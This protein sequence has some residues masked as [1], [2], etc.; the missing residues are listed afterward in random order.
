MTKN[1][2]EVA[3]KIACDYGYGSYRDAPL[4]FKQ[5]VLDEALKKVR[6]KSLI[7]RIF[8]V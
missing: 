3:D 4:K 5:R 7:K 6:K 8:R 1:V 2:I